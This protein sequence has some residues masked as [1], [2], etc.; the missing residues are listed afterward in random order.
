MQ[1]KFLAAGSEALMVVA[2]PDDETI[3]AGGLILNNPQVHWTILCLCRASDNDRAPKFAKV[4]K[5]LGAYGIIQDLEDE[6]RL[7]LKASIR[8]IKKIVTE[9]IGTKHFDYVFSHGASGEYGHE[10]HISTHLAILDLVKA[11]KIK[12]DQLWCFHYKKL[13]KYKLV[14]RAGADHIL[15]LN[16]K[17]FKQK[18]DLMTK[19]YGFDPNGIDAGYCTNPEA[20]QRIL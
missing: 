15:K 19:I 5:A 8:P 16:N 4:A 11:K 6:G 2:H 1:K 3:W 7:S 14:A 18:L 10:R 20:Y 9:I 17:L 13:S 12:T